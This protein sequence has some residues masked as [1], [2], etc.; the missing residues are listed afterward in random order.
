[1]FLVF[2]LVSAVYITKKYKNN[3]YKAIALVP[4]VSCLIFGILNDVVCKLYP[5]FGI[6]CEKM[7][8]HQAILT[9]ENYLNVINYLPLILAFLVLGSIM[10]NILLIFRNLENNIAVVIYILGLMSRIALGFSPT[11][12]ASTDRTFLFFEFALIMITILIWQEFVKETDK[13]PVKAR[14]NLA[15]LI[16]C[17]AILQYFHTIIYTGM[18]QM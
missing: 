8:A 10:L 15:T 11:V 17:L 16:V 13:T 1:M 6:F 5:Y 2:S 7:N 14:T 4:V 3:L 18:S 9:P 12:F